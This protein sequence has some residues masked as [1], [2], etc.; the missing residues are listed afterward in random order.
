M[1]ARA[2]DL[3]RGLKAMAGAFVG[4]SGWQGARGC[5]LVALAAV[6]DGASILLLVPMLSAVVGTGN[7]RVAATLRGFGFVAPETQLGVLVAGF[8]AVALFRLAIN[9]ARD[10]TLN[11]L[12]TGFVEAER[13]R[14][15]AHV[16]SA[17]WTRVAQLSHTHVTNLLSMEVNRVSSALQL[18]LQ[19]TVAL[20]MLV[21]QTAI[22]FVLAPL[23]TTALLLVFAG[24]A[25][26]FLLSGATIGR[27]GADLVQTNKLMMAHSGA[28]LQ[29]LKTAIAQNAQSRFL[30]EY[31][32][33]LRSSRRITTQFARQTARSRLV[34]GTATSLLAAATVYL[35]FAVFHVEPVLLITVLVIFARMSGPMMQLFQSS[36]Q[37]VFS[38]P[39][40]LAVRALGE[41]LG[42]T[43][44]PASPA[45]PPPAGAIELDR[46]SYRHPGGG[47]VTQVSLTIAPGSFVGV[48][49][50]SGAGK[51]TLVDLIAGLL[52]PQTGAV[53]VGGQRLDA[54]GRRGWASCIAYV[55]QEGFLFHD[56][57]RRN[58]T[59]SSPAASDAEIADALALA[60]ATELVARLDQGLE[61]VIG[62]RGSLVSGGERQRLGLAR[63]LLARPRLL[64]LDEAAN[65]ID[66]ESEAALLARIA[67]LAQRPT[68]LMISHRDASLRFC[69]CVIRV[70]AGTV[71]ISAEESAARQS[72]PA[73]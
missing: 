42:D 22:A 40:F 14:L 25:L 58:L 73:D 11:A 23:L 72:T 47:G 6:L 27:M 18:L 26:A 57:V 53:S 4:H 7:G 66:A 65:A 46:A 50:P 2:G 59:W 71:A 43:A 16:A 28:F 9:Y 68:I 61:T 45:I 69:D 15:L 67:A 56:S 33:V 51:T 29:G 70:D 5:L 64:V 24:A 52:E 21:V 41:Q 49:G 60:G 44:D 34:L 32:T 35:G 37:M 3:W 36:Q 13:N 10:L 12:Q 62:E 55:A 19:S 54:A 20:V 1:L 17:P 30:G 48:A 8:L 38:L 31:A 63:A 39:S